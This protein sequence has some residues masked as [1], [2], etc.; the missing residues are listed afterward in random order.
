LIVVN[1]HRILSGQ[2]L[3]L[4]SQD[5]H[6][7][8]V[9]VEKEEQ[10]EILDSIKSFVRDRIPARLQIQPDQGV[11]VITPIHRGLLGTIHINQ[12]LQALLNPDGEP[13][14]HGSTSFRLGDRVMQ[15][16]N[17]YDKGVFNGDLGKVVNI[18]KDSNRLAVQFDRER[19]EYPCA[20][21]D[22]LSLAYA[23]SV[24]KS[25]GSEYPAVVIP[26]HTS[27]YLMLNRSIF[28]TAI[29]R[30]KKL[31]VLIGSRKALAMAM[32]N[33]RVDNRF[34]GLKERL[35]AFG[36]PLIDGK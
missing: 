2:S 8:F 18:D 35:R 30:A 17:N 20:D 29:T 3:L 26:I 25:Q 21:L 7:D 28:Y 27:H 11:Q 10:E 12:Q 6:A 4:R 15:L 14:Q 24:H 19:V 5:T 23:T 34:T 16:R 36:N 9:F 22:E 33:V 13:V 32:R 31:A 1:A